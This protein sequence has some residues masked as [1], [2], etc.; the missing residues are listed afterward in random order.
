[1]LNSGS[2]FIRNQL[3]HI[4]FILKYQYCENDTF[5][6]FHPGILERGNTS[7]GGTGGF[8]QGIIFQR[9]DGSSS[10]CK[11]LISTQTSRTKLNLNNVLVS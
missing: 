2:Y 9:A 5:E 1:M 11:A 4:L 6:P 3:Q 10:I 7:N 8:S